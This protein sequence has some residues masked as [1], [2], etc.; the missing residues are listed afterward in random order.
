MHYPTDRITHTTIYVISVLER[1]LEQE[2]DP[3][4]HYELSIRW[5]IQLSYMSLPPIEESEMT[6]DD[7][8]QNYNKTGEYCTLHEYIY[9][10]YIYVITLLCSLICRGYWWFYSR[11]VSFIS[12]TSTE[13]NKQANKLNKTFRDH[14]CMRE[15]SLAIAK[16]MADYTYQKNLEVKYM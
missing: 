7:R 6:E 13:A 16:L 15:I 11:K 12:D 10:N 2:I 3:W 8:Q 4:D 5:P 9:N 1:W 14:G